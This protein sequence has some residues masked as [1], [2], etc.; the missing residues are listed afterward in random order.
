MVDVRQWL[1]LQR[2]TKKPVAQLGF[3]EW[4]QKFLSYLDQH[5]R[6]T[7]P[8]L[9][10]LIDCLGLRGCQTLAASIFNFL[11]PEVYRDF[12][13]ARQEVGK[14]AKTGLLKA[15]RDLR[16]AATSYRKLLALVSVLEIRGLL[17][18]DA[19]P[20]LPEFIEKEATRLDHQMELAAVAFSKKR[21]GINENHCL[22]IQMQEFIKEFGRRWNKNLPPTAARELTASHIA[23]LLEA[24]KTALGQPENSTI[25]D[26]ASIDKALRRHKHNRL[27]S[28][29]LKAAAHRDCDRCRP[30]STA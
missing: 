8:S 26:A 18:A 1:D 19:P 10:A 22:L 27:L 4:S 13:A 17:G 3:K 23:D 28:E 7:N 2:Q 21:M 5:T 12:R 6:R 20:D 25:T 24:G 11:R 29:M 9:M 16:R 30:P 14:R 15:V